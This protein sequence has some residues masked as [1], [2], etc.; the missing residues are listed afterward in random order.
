MNHKFDPERLRPPE[1]A[2]EPDPRN[3]IFVRINLTDGTSQPIELADHH[4]GVSACV[5]HAGVPEDIVIQFETARNVY[6]YS[7]F[8]YRFF[9]VA[10]HQS[11]ACLELALR[12]RLKE[13][14]RTGKIRGKRPTLRPLLEYTITHGFGK[15]R[16]L[17]GMAKWRGFGLELRENAR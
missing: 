4:E 5:L 13:E 9:P 17:F 3:T 7:W 1:F 12:L 10:E 11:L 2:C 16:R 8:I 14:I 15:E 6:L